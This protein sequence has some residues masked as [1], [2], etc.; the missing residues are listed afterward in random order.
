MTTNPN[1]ETG[2]IIIL[3]EGEYSDYRTGPLFRC[4]KDLNIE[5]LAKEFYPN[6]P[7]SEWN[8][9]RRVADASTF[10]LWL[11]QNGWVE[12]IEYREVH[13]GSYGTFECCGFTPEH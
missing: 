1:F 5:T 3:A 7:V 4:V 10:T 11:T 2:D 9:D 6:A 12:E 13:V 8:E